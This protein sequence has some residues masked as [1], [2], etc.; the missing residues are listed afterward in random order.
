MTLQ[1]ERVH[2]RRLA[3]SA[4]SLSAAWVGLPWVTAMTE[5]HLLI[6]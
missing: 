5:A 6:E 4:A 1:R 3:G 2:P